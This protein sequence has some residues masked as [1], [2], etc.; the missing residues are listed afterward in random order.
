MNKVR[1]ASSAETVCASWLRGTS[2]SSM[3]GLAAIWAAARRAAAERGRTASA[4][5]VKPSNT[6]L[7]VASTSA[8]TTA[9]GSMPSGS[10]AMTR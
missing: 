3:L 4:C 9:T 1:R 6:L 2:V 10:A 5:R 7:L 8:L